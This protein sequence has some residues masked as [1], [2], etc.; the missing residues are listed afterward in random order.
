MFDIGFAELLLIAV[1]G[2][3]VI[4]PERLPSTIRT[5]SLWIGRFR[6]SFNEI[7]SEIERE[8]GADDIRRQLHNESIMASLNEGRNALERQAKQISDDLN[9]IGDT[10][11]EDT[12]LDSATTSSEENVE[13]STLETAAVD[14]PQDDTAIPHQEDKH[15]Q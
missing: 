8:V 2:L 11:A 1:V 14:D 4:G 13:E 3:L 9:N 7:R 6:R 12:K 15:G 5:M 10:T